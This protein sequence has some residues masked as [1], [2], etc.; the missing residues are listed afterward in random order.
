MHTCVNN[1]I[2]FLNIVDD[3]LRAMVIN[4]L[5]VHTKVHLG[6]THQMKQFKYTSNMNYEQPKYYSLFRDMVC[7]N[8]RHWNLDDF[9]GPGLF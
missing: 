7:S 2:I 8:Y 6:T 5:N 3:L 1:M 9:Y 4:L